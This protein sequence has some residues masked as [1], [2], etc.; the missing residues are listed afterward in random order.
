VFIERVAGL[1]NGAAREGCDVVDVAPLILDRTASMLEDLGCEV[2]TAA[3]GADALEK[4]KPKNALKSSSL[5]SRCPD[6]TGTCLSVGFGTFFLRH[7]R[8]IPRFCAY[9]R[10]V[11]NAGESAREAGASR[12]WVG[13]L[14]YPAGLSGGAGLRRVDRAGG[15]AKL[16]DRLTCSIGAKVG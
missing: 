14:P 4:L 11:K 10:A 6:W 7:T 9:Q 3:S 13:S 12:K 1:P 16:G 15:L 5:I 2:V 8:L